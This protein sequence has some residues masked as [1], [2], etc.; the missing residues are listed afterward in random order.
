MA[1]TNDGRELVLD[2]IKSEDTRLRLYGNIDGQPFTSGLGTPNFT[3]TS[4]LSL[5]SSVVFSLQVQ[6]DT[7]EIVGVRLTDSTGTIIYFEKDFDS[8]FTYQA[9]GSFTVTTYNVAIS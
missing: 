1:I 7:L 6:G 9:D 2:A 4:S 3:G 5:S 8:V